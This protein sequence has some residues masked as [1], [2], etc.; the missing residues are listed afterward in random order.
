MPRPLRRSA[1][2][3]RSSLPHWCPRPLIESFWPK[4]ERRA[5]ATGN[6]GAALAQARHLLEI[7]WGSRTL[8]VPQ[9][10]VCDTESFRWFAA[11]LLAELPRF[12]A[13]YNGA[14]H[15]FRRAHR[16]RNTAQPV[17]DLTINGAWHEAPLWIWTSEN[18][19]RRRFFVR[20][21]ADRLQL[22][23]C[24][25]LKLDLPLA[26][27]DL[28]PT[29][30]RLGELGRAGVKI[31]SRALV[32]TLWAR[33]VLGDLFIHGIGGANYDQVTDLL[34][35]RFFGLAP[36]GLTVVSATLHL[37]VAHPAAAADD[38]R[39]IR[40]QLR[41]LE[42]HPESHADVP[43]DDAQGRQWAE[44]VALKRRWIDTPPTRAARRRAVGPFARPMRRCSR[45]WPRRANV[46]SRWNKKCGARARSSA[47][48]VGANMPSVSSP[49]RRCKNF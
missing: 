41:E 31:R 13:V 37:P 20:R 40:Q 3:C 26:A 25:G 6:L 27:G 48:S 45:W 18:P 9:G 19:R 29:V 39:T 36:P 21:H 11:H 33:L 22:C 32:T 14:V 49:P 46:C 17:P 15:E 2:A 38:L 35:A 7:E 4:V 28:R 12:A 10:Q 24:E 47:C 43:L 16:I 34:M 1:A 42:F 44:L 30:E 8:E 5:G 23:D